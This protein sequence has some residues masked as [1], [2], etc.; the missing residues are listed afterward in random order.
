MV[1]A[2]LSVPGRRDVFV[3]GDLAH[4]LDA[5]TGR[6]LPGVATVAMQQG[7][8][9]AKTILAERA[10]RARAAF[11]FVDQGQMATIGRARAVSEFRRLRFAGLFAWWFWLLVHIYRLTGFRNR[12][13]VMVQ[14]GW[15]FLTFDRGARLIVP[16]TWREYGSEQDHS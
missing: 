9:V 15:S 2:D 6:P 10:G 13:S 4:A 12:L 11:R 14:W 16:R 5:R 8:Y 1:E 3:V 7:I